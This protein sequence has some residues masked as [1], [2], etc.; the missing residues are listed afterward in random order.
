MW[1]QAILKLGA[2]A[3]REVSLAGERVG[4]S[5]K[6]LKVCLNSADDMITIVIG[7]DLVDVINRRMR[8]VGITWTEFQEQS[9]TNH[10]KCQA[11]DP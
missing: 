9:V 7:V 11:Q 6:L 3:D 8:W 2:D 5:H 1:V 10:S 4:C